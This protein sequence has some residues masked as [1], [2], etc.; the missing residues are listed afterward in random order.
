[1]ANK[2]NYRRATNLAYAALLRHNVPRLPVD[3]FALARSM[4]RVRLKSYTQLCWERGMTPDGFLAMGVSEHGFSLIK[5]GAAFILFNDRKDSRINRFTLAHEL[6]HLLLGHT[7]DD[8]TADLEANCFARN[9][10]CPIPV[11]RR[12]ELRQADDYCRLFDITPLAAETSIRHGGMDAW[13]I[14]DDHQSAVARLFEGVIE[15]YEPCLSLGWE[16]IG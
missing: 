10:L 9:L 1:M 16:G 15:A 2:P 13:N 4:P 8:K 12:L 7:R 3:V 14:S 6:G 5:G 11:I